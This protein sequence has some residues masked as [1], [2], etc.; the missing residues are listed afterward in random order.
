MQVV[1]RFALGILPLAMTPLFGY[2]IANGYLDLGASLGRGLIYAVDG[3]S[4]ILTFV[5]GMMRLGFAR[6]LGVH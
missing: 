5:Y 2:L 3:A 1:Y 6:F 4:V